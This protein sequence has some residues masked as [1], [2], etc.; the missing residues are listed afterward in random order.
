M[1]KS[2]TTAQSP[3]RA[4]AREAG[5]KTIG[6]D[7]GDKTSRYCMLGAGGET[8]SEGSVGTTRK[9]MTEKFGGLWRCRVAMEVGTH[10]PWVSR[11]L[12]SLGFE[13]FVAN[14][15]QVRLISESS[16]KNDRLD[17]QLLARLVRVDPQLLRPIRHRSEEAQEDLMTIR[18]RAA[19]VEART[20][21]I[22]SARGFAKALGERLPVCD[23]DSMGVEK[24]EALPAEMRER[25]RPLLEQVE[26]L[27]EKIQE[28][29]AKIEQIARTQ[30]PETELLRQVSGVGT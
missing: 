22:N 7:L 4:A 15:R 10:S 5:P 3:K 13:V 26:S 25:L 11:L 19:L 8:V 12:S 29:D 21:L 24:L 20:G 23:T 16:R 30:Y 17:A 14:A 9:A 18:V 1:K 28:S 6:M 27:T 2:N